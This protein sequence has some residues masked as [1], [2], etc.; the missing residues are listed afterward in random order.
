M[1]TIAFVVALVALRVG[2][3]ACERSSSIAEPAPDKSDELAIGV[4]F[5]LTGHLAATGQL[6]Q[7]GFDLALDE[8]NAAPLGRPKLQFLVEDDSSTVSGAVSAFN[9]LIHQ[10]GVSVILGP[11]SSSATQAAF[12]IAQDNQ[13][14]AIS[15]TS[16]ARGLSAL[17]DLC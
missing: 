16:G 1:K 8:I 5:P 11:A 6:M 14:V 10:E 13:V 12:P 7:Q 4:V 17:G 2:F 3:S 9:R 15:P